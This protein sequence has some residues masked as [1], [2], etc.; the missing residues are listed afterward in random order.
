[1]SNT[2]PSDDLEF[3]L[4]AELSSES[5]VKDAQ[6]AAKVSTSGL[7]PSSKYACLLPLTLRSQE[8]ILK[9][10]LRDQK[11]KQSPRDYCSSS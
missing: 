9:P 1:M 8:R 6:P 10:R 4:G 11:A 5:S 2:D 3:L 7:R